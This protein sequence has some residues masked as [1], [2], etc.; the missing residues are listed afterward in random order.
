MG[1][2]P[3]VAAPSPAS[4]A[5]PSVTDLSASLSVV[6][7]QLQTALAKLGGADAPSQQYGDPAAGRALA[8]IAAGIDA[9]D[10]VHM[11]T[12]ALHEHLQRLFGLFSAAGKTD[13][14]GLGVAS[15]ARMTA[16]G[17]RKLVRAAQLT[18]ER[19]TDVDVDLIFQ[20]VVRTRGARMS[21]GDMMVGLSMVAKRLYP[22]ERTQSSAFHRL[23]SEQ[24]LPWML[25][26]APA[27]PPAATNERA[28]CCAHPN[29]ES[30][31]GYTDLS[32]SLALMSNLAIVSDG[33]GRCGGTR[34][35]QARDGAPFLHQRSRLRAPTLPP[36][37]QATACTGIWSSSRRRQS[38]QLRGPARRR[39][40]HHQEV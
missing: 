15:G 35:R 9:P 34:T 33:G 27:R 25:Q 21:M 8:L 32:V 37:A 17:F 14:M 10:E 1:T 2:A 22:E 6:L 26:Y 40:T 23:L 7:D 5:E 18:C 29:E 19:C 4:D 16:L 24:M 36:R 31:Y 3:N 28:R 39:E 20:Q 13:S 12:R 11:E 38:A 30:S